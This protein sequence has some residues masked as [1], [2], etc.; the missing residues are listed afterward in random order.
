MGMINRLNPTPGALDFWNEFKKPT[1]Y[2]WP[3]LGVSALMTFTLMYQFTSESVLVPP[4]PPEVTYIASF[5]ADRTDAEIIASNIENQRNQDAVAALLE[6][7]EERKRE[8][9]RALGRA[10]GMD[11]DE[12][13]REAERERTAIEAAENARK[14]EIRR[15]AG[16]PEAGISE[17]EL[18]ARAAGENI[19]AE[20]NSVG[21]PVATPPQ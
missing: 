13:D 19:V 1:P 6:Q 15:R 7:N 16:L 5:P 11:V 10:S 9:Y 18:R 3:I 8:L 17:T 21:A 12:I 2:R 20:T 14:A 4:A